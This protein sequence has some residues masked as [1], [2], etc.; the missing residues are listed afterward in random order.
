MTTLF[1]TECQ[2]EVISNPALNIGQ[3]ADD[4]LRVSIGFLNFW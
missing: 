2:W 3:E 4:S 1:I